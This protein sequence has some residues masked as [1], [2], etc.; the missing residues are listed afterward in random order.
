MKKRQYSSLE[1]RLALAILKNLASTVEA[2]CAADNRASPIK[3]SIQI[4][5]FEDENPKR[6][7]I[8]FKGSDEV[9]ICSFWFSA[10]EIKDFILVEAVLFAE[11]EDDPI[12]SLTMMRSESAFHYD[13]GSE[14]LNDTIEWAPNADLS[15]KSWEKTLARFITLVEFSVNNNINYSMP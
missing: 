4:T 12:A 11:G 15:S 6:S 7:G 9:P 13:A 1:V 14:K 3:F 2:A 10:S 8:R 5:T